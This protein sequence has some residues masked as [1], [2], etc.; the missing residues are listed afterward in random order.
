M[1][2]QGNILYENYYRHRKKELKPEQSYRV[3]FILIFAVGFIGIILDIFTN[4]NFISVPFSLLLIIIGII[5][6]LLNELYFSKSHESVSYSIYETGLEIPP[7]NKGIKQ[8]KKQF[9]KFSEIESFVT[10][11]NESNEGTVMKLWQKYW[12]DEIGE[13][14]TTDDLSN[15]RNE[16]SNYICFITKDQRL[17]SLNRS[18]IYNVDLFIKHVKERMEAGHISIS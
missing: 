16:F 6:I 13:K 3:I 11:I 7:S 2:E 1:N 8:A 5:F 9:L 12:T 4:Y 14:I 18:S 17:I 10:Q 15:A